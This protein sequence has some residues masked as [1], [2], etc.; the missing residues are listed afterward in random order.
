MVNS[1]LIRKSLL[2]LVIQKQVVQLV[3][4]MQEIQSQLLSPATEY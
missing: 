4:Q 3:V 2:K 1:Y